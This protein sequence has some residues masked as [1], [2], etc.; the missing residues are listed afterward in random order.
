MNAN[1][2]LILLQ[3]K[4]NSLQNFQIDYEEFRKVYINVF[5]SIKNEESFKNNFF[6]TMGKN[7]EIISDYQNDIYYTYI[8]ESI[9]PISKLIKYKHPLTFY[10]N[11]IELIP[12]PTFGTLEMTT[13]CAF[14][15]APDNDPLIVIS[16]GLIDLIQEFSTLLAASILYGM[17]DES[18]QE[19]IIR[20]YIDFIIC[21]IFYNNKLA[22]NLWLLENE[23]DENFMPLKDEL[24]KTALL[25]VFAHE[26]SHLVLGHIGKSK[27]ITINDINVDIKNFSWKQE[28]DADLLGTR[29]ALSNRPLTKLTGIFLALESLQ[30]SSIY[31]MHDTKTHP[32]L[33]KRLSSIREYVQKNGYDP[34][35]CY[36]FEMLV[37]PMSI[38]VKLFI[39]YINENNMHFGNDN[40]LKIQKLIYNDFPIIPQKSMFSNDK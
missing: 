8:K 17:H 37:E 13:H 30:L 24:F 14:S 29:I 7:P 34:I 2:F 40:L 28:F 16:E 3:K 27:T 15:V 12:I 1:E 18:I 38:Q 33:I 19:N 11:E 36:M 5:G 20:H 35:S 32:A 10:G 4:H 9:K 23:V 25:F 31:V 6:L 21:I 22:A 26:Y 39:K